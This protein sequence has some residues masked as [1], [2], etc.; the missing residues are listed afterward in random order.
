MRLHQLGS[1]TGFNLSSS[2]VFGASTAS[3]RTD[4]LEKIAIIVLNVSSWHREIFYLIKYNNY[5]NY[6]EILIE[7]EYITLHSKSF[8]LCTVLKIKQK[9]Y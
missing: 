6:I 9:Q 4:A 7:S 2:C 5:W 3:V 8:K 1:C